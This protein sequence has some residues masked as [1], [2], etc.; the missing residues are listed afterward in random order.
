M[1]RRA[2]VI[3]PFSN[4]DKILPLASI[5]QS[6]IEGFRGE[7]KRVPFFPYNQEGCSC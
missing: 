3:F 4:I 7:K 6:R 1:Q 5:S 2:C